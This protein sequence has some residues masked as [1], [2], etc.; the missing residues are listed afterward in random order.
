[1]FLKIEGNA[2]W[3]YTKG[4]N[5]MNSINLVLMDVLITW[6]CSLSQVT[7]VMYARIC[8]S[9]TRDLQNKECNIVFPSQA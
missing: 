3:I 4:N 6:Y 9:I 1:M 2:K 7:S 8:A 5:W